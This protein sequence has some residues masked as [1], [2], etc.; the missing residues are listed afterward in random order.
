M[1]DRD[2]YLKRYAPDHPW[3]RKGGYVREHVRLM[4]LKIG[5]RIAV[6][7]IVHHRDHDRT[8]NA[9]DNLEL[10]LCGEHSRHHRQHDIHRRERDSMGR[11]GCSRY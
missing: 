1:L 7:E 5:R 9:I 2:G 6:G 10:A 3:P 11:F 8:N 4:E